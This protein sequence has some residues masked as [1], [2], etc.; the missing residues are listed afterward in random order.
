MRLPHL[1]SPFCVSKVRRMSEDSIDFASLHT[2]KP[3]HQG[4]FFQIKFE[5]EEFNVETN[6]YYGA[7]VSGDH[8]SFGGYL[9][10]MNEFVSSTILYTICQLR[11][12]SMFKAPR[13]LMGRDE[14]GFRLFSKVVPGFKGVTFREIEVNPSS[15]Y[16]GGLTTAMQ[17][18]D[19][20]VLNFGTARNPTSGD[21]IYAKIDT[22]TL[23]PSG[24]E[25]HGGIWFNHLEPAVMQELVGHAPPTQIRFGSHVAKEGIFASARHEETVKFVADPSRDGCL[26]VKKGCEENFSY[27]MAG[28]KDF[29]DM[30]LEF[31]SFIEEKI[32]KD[33]KDINPALAE[34]E[35]AHVKASC[36]QFPILQKTI[37]EYF[38]AE[39]KLYYELY[40]DSKEESIWRDLELTT[41]KQTAAAT[42]GD[43]L[44]ASA[45]EG[46]PKASP[47]TARKADTAKSLSSMG[48]EQVRGNTFFG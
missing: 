10:L 15:C 32:L 48:G 6:S 14:N 38:K 31:M 42:A 46:T 4:Q 41:Y 34:A 18:V 25:S 30:P 44:Q 22:N 29:L 7:K 23:H 9:P 45:A 40:P 21:I 47:A 35:R 39:L 11:D 43:L 19:P 28:V 36:A 17:E 8:T 13:V 27:F 2:T 12:E 16:L 37:A 26:K 5:D 24:R 3:E 1:L 20:N 33:L